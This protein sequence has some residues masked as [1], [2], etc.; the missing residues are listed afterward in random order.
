MCIVNGI[1]IVS[2][3]ILFMCTVALYRY[4][5]V[6]SFQ[7][8]EMRYLPINAYIIDN[9]DMTVQ[10]TQMQ[11]WIEPDDVKDVFREVN[12]LFFNKVGIEW[13]LNDIDV[14]DAPEDAELEFISELTRDT[15]KYP[16]KYRYEA[17]TSLIP[18]GKYSRKFNNIYFTTF[19]G[20]TRQGNAN[21]NSRNRTIDVENDIHFTM[22]GTHSNKQNRGKAPV[23]RRLLHKDG[24]PSIA[25]T[26]A[27]E[28]AH[29][30]GLNHLN[31]NVDNIMNATTSSLKYT[32]AQE[33]TMEGQ[34]DMF[35]NIYEERGISQNFDNL[36]DGVDTERPPHR[37]RQ[38][39]N[40]WS[41]FA[42]A[43]WKA[44]RRF[45]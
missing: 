38:R 22:I 11:N 9:M 34:L 7:V 16:D 20:N 19:T 45:M 33:E 8:K 6:D 36:S 43:W 1:L 31:S 23:K 12:T 24:K 3:V 18:E 14:Y 40:V 32:E 37:P 26:V 21:V 44:S 27:H 2:L 35:R 4:K 41:L 39:P 13:V 10:G 29:V 5:S 42:D 17:Y 28:L 15:T 30:L 25:F